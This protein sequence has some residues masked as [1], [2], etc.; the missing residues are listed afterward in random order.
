[1]V[2]HR[3]DWRVQAC[4]TLRSCVTQK[5]RHELCACR[6][7]LHA[8]GRRER[9]SENVLSLCVV[10]GSPHNCGAQALLCLLGI[11]HVP[12]VPSLSCETLNTL[13]RNLPELSLVNL[14]KDSAANTSRAA[15]QAPRSRHA[16]TTLLTCLQQPQPPTQ[17]STWGAPPNPPHY[18]KSSSSRRRFL[19]VASCALSCRITASTLAALPKDA[20]GPA[21][22]GGA[23]PDGT[24]TTPVSAV[25]PSCCPALPLLLPPLV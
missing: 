15:A 16:L 2:S 22:S 20:G 1:M 4:Q 23:M 12:L 3:W 6:N 11:T 19:A 25:P 14:C 8:A 17:M 9:L 7:E 5:A 10:Q 24:A 13:Q 18:Y 21:H